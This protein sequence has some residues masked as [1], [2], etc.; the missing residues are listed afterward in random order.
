MIVAL[1]MLPII[2]FKYNNYDIIY[3]YI[4]NVQYFYIVTY[5]TREKYSKHIL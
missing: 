4:S 2:K 5:Y 3:I 1:V